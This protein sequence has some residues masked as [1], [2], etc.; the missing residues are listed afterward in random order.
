MT[1]DQDPP[2]QDEPDLACTDQQ[3]EKALGA[4]VDPDARVRA[5]DLLAAVLAMYG[6]G[7]RRAVELARAVRADDVV[8]GWADEPQVAALLD[9]HDAAGPH[10][11]PVDTSEAR[12]A[13]HDVERL[14]EQLLDEAPTSRAEP[15]RTAV[16]AVVDLHGFCLYRMALVVG[17]S[18]PERLVRRLAGDDLI[19]SLLLAHG[20][21][22]DPVEQR[23]R[24]VLDE[25]ARIGE[26]LAR[27]E[28]VQVG[29][30][31]LHLQVVGESPEDAWR[32]RQTVEREVQERLPDLIDVRIEGGREPGERPAA[33][34]IPLTSLSVRRPDGRRAPLGAAE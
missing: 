27:V 13:E 22:P 25:L 2:T 24:A 17:A 16:A 26:P 32:F 6:H 18:G 4:I 23:A 9:L 15:V 11:A 34:S 31:Q 30:G 19:G 28:T 33:V 29:P 10:P 14:T 20:L 3:V 1:Q 7:I 8:A 12:R 21:H 5:E